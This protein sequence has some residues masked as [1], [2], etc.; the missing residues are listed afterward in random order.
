[1]ARKKRLGQLRNQLRGAILLAFP[2]FNAMSNQP[3]TTHLPALS[4]GRANAGHHPEKRPQTLCSNMATPSPMRP[5]A[6]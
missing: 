3:E 6:P 4:P 5:V 2:E 1:M